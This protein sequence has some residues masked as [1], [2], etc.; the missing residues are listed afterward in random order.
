AGSALLELR[1]VAPVD[2]LHRGTAVVLPGR[3][4]IAVI[5]AAGPAVHRPVEYRVHRLWV[6]ALC[7]AGGGDIPV[8]NVGSGV[9][10]VNAVG[11]MT[12]DLDLTLGSIG[13]VTAVCHPQ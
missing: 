8:A 12:V 1:G 9:V 6:V 11:G 3:F 10:D 13:F 5:E 7:E 4:R 2:G